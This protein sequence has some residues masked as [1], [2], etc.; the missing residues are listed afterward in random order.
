MPAP[1]ITPGELHDRRAPPPL[2]V[3]LD[4]RF[5]VAAGP[6]RDAYERGH[7]PGAVFIDL[8]RDLAGPPG[9]SG[10]HPL[11]SAGEFT[12]AMRAAGVSA[13]RSVVVYDQATGVMAARAWWLL[14]Y[15]GHADVAVLDGGLAAWTE[16][17][18]PIATGPEPAPAA[19]GFTARPGALPIL[20][21]HS[22]AALPANGILIDARTPERFRGESEPLD[23]VAGH[24][25]GARNRSTRDNVLPSGRFADPVTLRGEFERL[26]ARPGVA[27]GTYCGSGVTAAHQVLALELAGIEAALYPGSWSEWVA[28]P[29]RPVATGPA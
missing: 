18:L 16:A 6:Q 3:L 26:G 10:R 14:R 4:I 17:A 29:S 15:F 1:L 27:V 11:P 5:D 23:R 9:A 28:D 8:N 21:A 7:L 2:P 24:I 19:G 20:D 22:A 13:D 25:P 12:R